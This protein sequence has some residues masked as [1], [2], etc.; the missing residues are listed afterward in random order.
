MLTTEPIV[1]AMHRLPFLPF[2][3][4]MRGGKVHE[5]RHPDYIAVSPTGRSAV[6]LNVD[7]MEIVNVRLV[8]ELV[9]PGLAEDQVAAGT[10]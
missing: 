4:H 6:I 1:E 9:V 7:G 3:I 2:R 8:A 5:V 10:A